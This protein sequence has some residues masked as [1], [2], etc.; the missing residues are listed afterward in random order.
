MLCHTSAG[1]GV[2]RGSLVRGYCDVAR[3]CRALLLLLEHNPEHFY[4]RALNSAITR[5]VNSSLLRQSHRSNITP[6]L[7]KTKTLNSTSPCHSLKKR[8]G[9]FTCR[10]LCVSRVTSCCDISSCLGVAAI[11]LFVCVTGIAGIFSVCS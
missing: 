10:P 2:A 11:P 6:L 3:R 5:L 8:A 9:V 4:S 7:K 1:W